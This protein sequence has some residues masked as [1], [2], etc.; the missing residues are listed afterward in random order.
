MSREKKAPEDEGSVSLGNPN[1]PPSSKPE[2]FSPEAWNRIVAEAAR[3]VRLNEQQ[4]PR[5]YPETPDE[6]IL[7]RLD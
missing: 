3:V 6:E 7:A 5:P 4:N 2:P 1:Q